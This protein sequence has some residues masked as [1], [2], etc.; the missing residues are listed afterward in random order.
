MKIRKASYI[1][2]FVLFYLLI[3]AGTVVAYGLGW[4][5][6][7]HRVAEY[8][9]SYNRIQ[10]DIRDDSGNYV[11][12][13]SLVTGV[14]LKYPNGTTVTLGELM[15]EYYQYIV[16]QFLPDSSQWN[17][18][19]P[20]MISGFFADIESPLVIGT[21]TLEVSMEN[22]Q[23]LTTTTNFDY[24][25]D[26]PIISSRS[27]QIHTDSTGN[28]HWTWRIPEQLLSLANTY[29]LQVRAGV[30]AM[31]NGEMVALYW[32]N[33]PIEV[34]YSIV[35]SSTYQ[36][37][38]NQADELHFLFQVR[39]S[40]NNARAYSKIIISDPSNTVSIVPKKTVVVI[41]LN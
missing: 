11:N 27:F 23:I 13:K 30:A 10:F 38:V 34:G 22:G 37:L 5:S 32:P 39:T 1:I 36:N 41:P 14:V 40:N 7:Q 21:Y 15:L 35:P 26:L 16:A 28:V 18:S 31:F 17:H 25:L 2:L 24:L 33:L 20:E 9:E 6:I 12:S 29:D 8:R 4:S 19:P 3:H